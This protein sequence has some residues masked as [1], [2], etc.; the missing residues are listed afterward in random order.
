MAHWT[1]LVAA[2]RALAIIGLVIVVSVFTAS[3]ATA[4]VS[5]SKE[6]PAAVVAAG[7]LTAIGLAVA[8]SEDS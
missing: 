3:I 8:A 5:L 1:T 2:A 6:L 4:L 7:I